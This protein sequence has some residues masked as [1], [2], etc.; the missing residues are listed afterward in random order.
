MKQARILIQRI[1]SP[2]GKN[3]AQAKSVVFS[4]GDSESRINQTVTVKIS[5]GSSSSSSSSSSSDSSARH[6]VV[7]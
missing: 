4:S 5:A 1:A 6:Q 7:K 3:T 2:D